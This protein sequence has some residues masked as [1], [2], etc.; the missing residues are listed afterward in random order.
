M[1]YIEMYERVYRSGLNSCIHI[2]RV[3]IALYTVIRNEIE[4]IV[5]P[6]V[7]CSLSFID[8]FKYQIRGFLK[9]SI[10]NAQHI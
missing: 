8:N 3:A 7:T 10:N 1:I 6:D 9:M 5:E 4:H 2:L